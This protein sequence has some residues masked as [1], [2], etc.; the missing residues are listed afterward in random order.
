MS[1]EPGRKAGKCLESR[2]VIKK[3][4]ACEKPTNI[5]VKPGNVSKVGKSLKKPGDGSAYEK[6]TNM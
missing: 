4:A 3:T 5:N 6:P 1:R 2:E